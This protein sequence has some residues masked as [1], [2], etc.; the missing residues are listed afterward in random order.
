MIREYVEIIESFKKEVFQNNL[1]A[2]L[3]NIKDIKHSIRYS[4]YNN[5][6]SNNSIYSALIIYESDNRIVWKET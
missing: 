3:K 6:N 2:F 1:E 5:K 4:V